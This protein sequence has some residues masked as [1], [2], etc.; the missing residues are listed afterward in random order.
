[1]LR[2]HY[3]DV[4]EPETVAPDTI[5]DNVFNTFT[6]NPTEDTSPKFIVIHEFGIRP[7]DLDQKVIDKIEQDAKYIQSHPEVF[8]IVSP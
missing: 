4:V 2:Q 5:F 6:P 3:F 1:M 8:G 7:S